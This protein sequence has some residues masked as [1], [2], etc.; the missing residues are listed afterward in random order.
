MNDG[1]SVTWWKQPE[2]L[3]TVVRK[4]ERVHTQR[5]A[6]DMNGCRYYYDLPE[7]YDMSREINGPADQLR[8]FRDARGIGY[9]KTAE[10]VDAGVAQVFTALRANVVPVAAGYKIESDCRKLSLI[11]DSIM[12]SINFDSLARDALKDCAIMTNGWVH[13]D[14]DEGGLI[15]GQTLDPM[16]VFWH[17]G[18]GVDP[19]S[20]FHSMGVSRDQVADLRPSMARKI[21]D[22]PTW[23]RQ[24]VV[25]VD[26]PMSRDEDTVRIDIGYHRAD[27][28]GKNGRAV[29][30]CGDVVLD[31]RPWPHRVLPIV[32]IRWKANRRSIAGVP[33]SRQVIPYH[34]NINR[35]HVAALESL[36]GA[37][38]HLLVHE[39]D[40][41]QFMSDVPFKK[42]TWRGAHKPEISTPNPVSPQI[43]E[44]IDRLGAQPYTETGINQSAAAG[45]RPTGLNSAP[46]QREWIDNASRRTSET[47]ANLAD[48]YVAVGKVILAVAKTAYS[49]RKMVIR[50]PGTGLLSEVDWEKLDLREDQYQVRF[51]ESSGLSKTYAGMVEELTDLQSRGAVS[52]AAATRALAGRIPDIASTANRSNAAEDL[53]N[54]LVA[55]ALEGTFGM[56]PSIDSQCVEAV[57]RIGAA[58]WQRAQ[59]NV[60][61]SPEQDRGVEVLRRLVEAARRKTS[62]PTPPVTDAE[63]PTPE[64]PPPMMTPPPM[65]A[66]PMAPP[67]ETLP[68]E[69][70]I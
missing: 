32:P 48:F 35:L 20:I 54:K 28:N 45:M 66:A 62:P 64:A 56:P 11:I 41:D 46:A 15:R 42:V 34:R 5:I 50:A 36:E 24:H 61:R 47:S 55:D 26:F 49:D 68:P 58:E 38:P 37:V 57:V 70:Q 33:L 1:N 69:G 51:R 65:D 25:G 67:L 44:Q 10:I 31:D 21:A 13:I 52:A 16:C 19:V 14:V 18:E 7:T 17:Q 39:T 53:A 6:H 4:L 40:S 43:F 3:S 22:M 59:L 9:N 27:A 23:R 8:D 12:D 2:Y 60:D 30:A 29:I 63:P